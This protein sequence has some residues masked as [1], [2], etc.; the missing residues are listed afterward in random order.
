MVAY[1]ARAHTA[2]SIESANPR[3][4]YAFS[5]GGL[6]MDIT[7]PLTQLETTELVRRLQDTELAYLF[8]HALVQ[9]TAY[10]SL[11]KNERKRLHRMI[12]ETLER[13]YP[14]AVEEN[15]ALLTKH[16]LE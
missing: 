11:L 10:T 8:K 7:A 15:A 1:C 3:P 12:G 5:R 14:N 2:D 13:E 4:A 6:R 9:D 16:Y